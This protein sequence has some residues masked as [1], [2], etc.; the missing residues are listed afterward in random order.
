MANEP[1]RIPR[2]DHR[3]LR[4]LGD[5][6]GA[7][8]G[9]PSAVLAGAGGERQVGGRHGGR[10]PPVR[11]PGRDGAH[12]SPGRGCG[13]HG[14]RS[15]WCFSARR[16]RP[17]WSWRRRRWRRACGSSTSRGPSGWRWMNIHAGTGSPIRA[18]TSS[19]WPAT[20]CRR[21][22]A[23]GDI[24]QAKLVSN[25]GCYAT[26]STLAT[27]A[28]LRGGRDR[29]GRDRHR[30]Q[31]RDDGRRAQ[32]DRGDVV[33]RARRRLPGLQGAQAPA[34]AR[35]RADAG[36]GRRRRAARHLHAVL[37]AAAA[38][39]PGHG[40]RAAL[41]REDRRRRGGGHQGVRRRSP[42]LAGDEAGGGAPPRRGGDEPRPHGRRRR[43]GARG[44]D[45]LRRHRQPGQ[46]GRRAGGPERQ[47]DVRARRD[48]RASS[49]SEGLHLE[50]HEE[51]DRQQELRP[52]D[53]FP[54]RRRGRRREGGWRRP[55]GP[56]AGRLGD[57]L[58][59]GRRR[60][61]QQDVRRAGPL[62]GDAA[63]GQRNPR[64]R[65]QQRQR[66]RA[67][68]PGRRRRRARRRRPPSPRRWA[69]APT[70]S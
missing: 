68:R 64:H 35:D 63:P 21:R 67:D 45:R 37:P 15:I 17:R 2:R 42:L 20:P 43:S 8:S 32:G 49:S 34:H 19:R 5:G 29:Q 58:R 33:H 55:Q 54:L 18:P 22:G 4:L 41:A 59:G 62:L 36:A 52:P 11:R 70:T 56:G 25:P 1:S 66:Q 24:R 40:L 12:P 3:R 65:R 27:L 51:R 48:G 53:R 60:H 61:R 6:A 9:G 31:E 47:P 44:R 28:L 16:P 50:R 14:R 69:S 57:P 46:R 39:D 26:A 7:S 10:S 38:R 30:R 23:S 13:G